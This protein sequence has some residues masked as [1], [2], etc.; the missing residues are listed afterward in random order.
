M[1]VFLAVVAALASTGFT[2]DLVRDLRRGFR[3][4]TSAYAAGIGMFAVATWALVAGLGTGWTGAS[5]R[6]FFL[7]GGVLNI[8]A[9]ALGSVFLVIGRRT[10]HVLTVL[11]G[12]FA[13]IAVTLVTTTP[14]ADPLPAG[15]VPEAV[16]PAI[17]DQGFGPRLLAAIG[18]GGGAT[19]LIILSAISIARFWRKNRPLVTGNALI[20]AGTLAAASGGTAVGLL[21]E[22]A[23]FE[24]SLLLASTLIWL[25]YRTTRGARAHS[26]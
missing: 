6:T 18:G 10:G 24:L 4:H 1:D 26:G 11:F 25:G 15:G 19:M 21:G 3:P 22:T 9:L 2:L 12:G 14:F 20:L 17:A 23:T 16:F 13:A 8:P 7:F 5:Y